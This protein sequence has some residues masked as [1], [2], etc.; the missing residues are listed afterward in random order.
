MRVIPAQRCVIVGVDGSPNS[1]A[2]LHRAATEA[3][4][5]SARLDVVQV[6]DRQRRAGALPG[7]TRLAAWLR[8][9]NLVARELPR[10][11]HVTTRLRIAFGSPPGALIRAAAKAELLLVG[12]RGHSEHGGDLLGGDTVRRLLAAA[13][14][15]VIICADQAASRQ[16][17]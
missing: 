17:A 15:E 2:A 3:A 11:Q 9:R 6:V 16:E 4:R 14:C 1:I 8:L 13:P 7:L 12:A 10:S 5:R